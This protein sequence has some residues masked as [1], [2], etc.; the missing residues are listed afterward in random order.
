MGR[1][2]VA[3]LL[4]VVLAAAGVLLASDHLRSGRIVALCGGVGLVVFSILEWGLGAGRARTGPG[5]G[6]WVLF[7]VGLVVIVAVGILGPSTGEQP[8][9]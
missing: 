3:V 7:V 6:I 1:G 8:G 9:P 2:W 5:I 4:G